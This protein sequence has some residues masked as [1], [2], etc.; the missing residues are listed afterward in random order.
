MD[1]GGVY[2]LWTARPYVGGPKS[3]RASIG[4]DMGFAS[5]FFR[6]IPV[7]PSTGISRFFS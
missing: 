3:T 6:R 5:E 4:E 7:C 2:F 1:R